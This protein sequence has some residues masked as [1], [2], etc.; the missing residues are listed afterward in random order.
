MKNG[1][2]RYPL[3]ALVAPLILTAGCSSLGPCALYGCPRIDVRAGTDSRVAW[4][5]NP[6]KVA[7]IY[8]LRIVCGGKS[9]PE[10][11]YVLA[12]DE[13]IGPEEEIP[14]GPVAIPEF[15]DLGYPCW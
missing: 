1:R 8:S 4:L 3:A 9:G 12:R 14:L 10:P 15:E 13:T 6:G 7:K 2:R 5:V 11:G